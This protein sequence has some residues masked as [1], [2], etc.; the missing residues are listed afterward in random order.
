MA[1]KSQISNPK[2]QIW[3][4]VALAVCLLASVLPAQTRPN[5]LWIV[6]DDMGAEFPAYGEKAIQTPNVDRLVRE[7]TLFK[8][9]FLTASV[10]SPSRS[11]MITGMYQTS[12]GAHNHRSGRGAE[13]IQLP[14]GIEPVPVIFQRNGY[15]TANCSWPVKPAIG[16]TDYNFEWP[17]AMYDAGDWSA[18]KPGQPFFAQIHLHGGKHRNDNGRWYRQV[19]PQALGKLTDP[20]TVT[21]P[22]YYPRDPVFLQDW[23]EYL[24]TVRYADFQLG[25]ILK[26]LEAENILDQ[27][28]IIFMGDNGISHIREKQFLY[29]G[30][31]HTPFI[32]RG[33]GIARGAE[34]TDLIEHID[35]PA[36]SLAAA[37]IAVP[38]Q[39]QGRDIL[40]PAY[41]PR[42]AVFAAR[43]RC[44]ETVDHIRSVRTAQ[45][46]YIRNYLPKR[47]MLQPNDYKDMKP[48]HKR[49]RELAAEGKLDPAQQ[50]L[51]LAPERAPEELYDLQADP[52]EMTN[53]AADPKHQAMLAALR[54]RLDQWVKDTDDK[55]RNP[56]PASMFDS[57]MKAYLGN[58]PKPAVE[59]NIQLMKQWEKEGK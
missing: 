4:L 59:K 52:F 35:M 1:L 25:E 51:L 42:D 56:E 32:V 2:F 36:L 50:R 34:R 39:M 24:D 21:L 28:L 44:D 47:P 5:I 3:Q 18:R 16:K 11:A 13:K 58:K 55:G 7:G 41:K 26:R 27:T 17:R 33:P 49:L 6:L 23:A 37:S 8:N 57:D 38:K 30:G 29:D 48:M 40:S 31:I 15:Y 20:A 19:A 54:A 10:C 22:P 46:K 12:I 9:A 14:P 45:F 53:L 43:D